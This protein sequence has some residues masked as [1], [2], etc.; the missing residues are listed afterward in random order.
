MAATAPRSQDGP[1]NT[2]EHVSRANYLAIFAGA[3]SLQ[4]NEGRPKRIATAAQ[5]LMLFA[6]D[7]GSTRPGSTTP[8]DHCEV[9]HNTKWAAPHNGTTDVDSLSLMSGPDNRLLE[10]GGY[11]VTLGSRA[12]EWRPS[13]R[14]TRRRPPSNYYFNPHH[15][16]KREPATDDRDPP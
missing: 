13:R 12:I 1:S 5:R 9:N 14:S 10:N 16:T 8:F 7:G 4:L 2:H 3:K 11:T 6:R 15:I